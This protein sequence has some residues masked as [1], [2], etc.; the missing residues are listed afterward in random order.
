MLVIFVQLFYIYNT[1]PR[2]LEPFS[3]ARTKFK[4][5]PYQKNIGIV[6]TF[7]IKPEKDPIFSYSFCLS[8]NDG[9]PYKLEAVLTE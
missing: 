9:F 8:G 3:S 5:K 4:K 1:I 2:V 6:C 7:I